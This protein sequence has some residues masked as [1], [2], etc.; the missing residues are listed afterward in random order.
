MNLDEVLE[1]IC[2][3]DLLALATEVG[4]PSDLA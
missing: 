4:I 1:A 2:L 3:P